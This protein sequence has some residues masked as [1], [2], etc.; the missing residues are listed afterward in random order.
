MQHQITASQDLLDSQG[1]I[2]EPGFAKELLWRYDRSAIKAPKWRIKEWDYYYVGDDAHGLALTIADAGFVSNLAV[3]LLGYGASE[4]EPFHLN[5]AALGAFPLGRLNLPAT[6]VQGDIHAQVGNA[7]MHF[8]NDGSRRRLHGTFANYAKSGSELAFDITLTGIPQ[9][10]MVI[11]TPFAK[12]GRFYYNQKINCMAAD[13]T[14]SFKGTEYRFSSAKGA[15][16]TLDWGRGVWTYDNTWY[17]GSGSVLLDSGSRFGFNIG[18]GFGDTSAA[19][20]NMLFMDGRAHKLKDVSFDIPRKADGSYDYLA[21]WEFHE[22]D[23][24]FEMRFQPV[25]DRHDPVDLK[26]ICMVPHQVFGRMS[27][28]AILDDGT[29]VQLRDALVFAEHVHNRW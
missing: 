25:V 8:E 11:A 23:G 5:D 19:S 26:V 18:H 9:E 6:S 16:G 13:G 21:P 4:P 3:S 14:V 2:A 12:A 28:T 29:A 7:D 17:W 10:S 1:N 24:R 15:M 20:E 22:T 27:G